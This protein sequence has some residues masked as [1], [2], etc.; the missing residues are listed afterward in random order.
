[1]FLSEQG[2][3]WF[4]EHVDFFFAGEL[5]FC[6]TFELTGVQKQSEAPLLNVRVEPFVGRPFHFR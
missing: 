1:L 4:D 3:K 5:D 6:L 2:K